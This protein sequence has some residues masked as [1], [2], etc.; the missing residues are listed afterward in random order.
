MANCTNFSRV[1]L[2]VAIAV[3]LDRLFDYWPPEQADIDSIQPGLRVE[4]PFGKQ[5]KIG[6]VLGIVQAKD[7]SVDL[8]RLK[9]VE[10]ILDASPLLSAT[11]LKLL[12]WAS[13]YY[14]HAIGEV[15]ATAFPVALRQ[16]KPAVLQS[17]TAYGLTELGRQTLPE[18]LSRAPKQ[19]A[20]LALLGEQSGSVCETQLTEHKP[21]LK[22]LLAKGLVD[23]QAYRP[24][25]TAEKCRLGLA[26][27]AEQ[28]QAINA[29][30]ADLGRFAVSLLQGVTGSGKTEVYMQIIAAALAR[31][32]QVL[33]LLPEITLTPQ[34]EQRFR[35]RFNVPMVC[36]HSK[37]NDSQRL[38]AWLSMQQG[39]AAIML[40]TRSAL[41]TP[42]PRAGLII[43]D[44]EHDSSFKQ[45]EGFRFSARDVA[46][47]RGKM[48]NVPVLLGS[49]TPSLESLFN[50]AQQ[51]YRLLPLSARAGS[52]VQPVFQILDIRNKPL[53][54]GL[55]EPLIAAIGATLAKGQQVMLFLNRRGF[56]PVL[57]C[58]GCGW[59]SRCI[60]CDANMVIH[61]GERRLRC[62]HCGFEQ[63]LL[64]QCPA[65]NVG[66][67]QP[68]GMGTERIEY[69][70][71]ELFPDKSLVRLDK[72]TTQR[73]GSL[74]SYLEQI[75]HGQVDI[76][77]GTQMLA[78]GHHFPEVTLVAILDIDSGLFSVD[79][80]AGEKLAQM[81]VQVA[82]RAGRAGKAG[83]VIL[84]TR[85]PQH[86]LLMALIS[87]GYQAFA[88]NALQERRQAG[89][90]PFGY[91]ALIRCYA[92]NAREPQT[93]L[94]K[95][96]ELAEG[97]NQGQVQVL[98]PVPAPM[99]RRAGQFH[100]QLLL[101]SG[102]RLHLHRFLDE[103][104]PAV[105]R[106]KES[107]KL[108]WSIDVDP[109]DL[110]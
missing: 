41:F 6:V 34:L 81:I 45:Q 70:L 13:R 33:V 10:R 59:V 100:F 98:G 21:A 57:I 92:A 42:L 65:C 15:I 29:V 77:L 55:S 90:P 60:R 108:R 84:Q 107:S 20:L 3:P 4:V 73:K 63:N 58:H 32:L 2:Q 52:A 87:Q 79:F 64:K 105:T 18:Q 54:A 47:A 71:S 69:A 14:H 25:T 97:F 93:F 27:N 104:L 85:Q 94:G 88:D 40:G 24:E 101:Q 22:A 9:T 66:E 19:Q 44:E 43:L 36:F 37:L 109:A 86:P 53:Q 72:D 68:L 7:S 99:Q 30:V 110:Y 23:A 8:A 82:G 56:A 31:D 91:Q 102:Q 12:R 75:H 49:A 61:A 35:A 62:H 1:I 26:A 11:D 51:R 48:L 16:G 46:I 103:L 80:R 76:I 67:L 28:Q 74:E 78:K 50:A 38:Q 106:L 39:E 17:E 83:R 95:I 96:V 5:R 89:L